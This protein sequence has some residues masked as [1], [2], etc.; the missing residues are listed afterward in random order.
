MIFVEK[1]AE[2]AWGAEKP[3]IFPWSWISLIPSKSEELFL[4]LDQLIL[5][6]QQMSECLASL[7][8]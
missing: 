3:S 8:E 5:L 2:R 6:R 4:G 1:E 7:K